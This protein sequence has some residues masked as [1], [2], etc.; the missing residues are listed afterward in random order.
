MK[1]Y[2]LTV[3]TAAG[4]EIAT[5]HSTMTEVESAFA[6]IAGAARC[7]WSEIKNNETGETTRYE[8]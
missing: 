1:T 8:Y 7:E 5:D 3:A 2:T 6:K 4:I